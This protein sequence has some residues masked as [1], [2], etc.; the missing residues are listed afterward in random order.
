MPQSAGVDHSF[1]TRTASSR[2][3]MRA[4][5]QS[6]GAAPGM[7]QKAMAQN[8]RASGR[9]AG[10]PGGRPPLRLGISPRVPMRPDAGRGSTPRPSPAS[11]KSRHMPVLA[12]ASDAPPGMPGASPLPGRQ[13]AAPSC[14]RRATQRPPGQSRR[15]FGSPRR[16]QIKTVI[17][18]HCRSLAVNSVS[19]AVR[20]QTPRT[21]FGLALYRFLSGRTSLLFRYCALTAFSAKLPISS[22]LQAK[23]PFPVHRGTAEGLQGVNGPESEQ[24]LKQ[25]RSGSCSD[26]S[27]QPFPSSALLSCLLSQPPPWRRQQAP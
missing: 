13:Q 3:G 25:Q 23:P 19:C 26:A 7:R 4:P 14:R 22:F 17:I 12:L 21:D 2:P 27:Q 18:P 20:E 15:G 10:P 6:L 16:S 9:G 11:P 1:K 5:R 24:Q 8:C